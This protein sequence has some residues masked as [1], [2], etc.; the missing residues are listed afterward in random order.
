MAH[1]L[2][3]LG[4][5]PAPPSQ[6]LGA[7][8]PELASLRARM[9]ARDAALAHVSGQPGAREAVTAFIA[10][11]LASRDTEV[12]SLRE[13]LRARDAA[14]ASLWGHARARKATL[15]SML[16]QLGARS[17][18]AAALRAQLAAATTALTARDTVL[19]STSAELASARAQLAA[20]TTALTARDT[21]AASATTELASAREQLTSTI[22]A[23]AALQGTHAEL[24]LK[25]Q[26][27]E[28][29]VRGLCEHVEMLGA[30]LEEAQA[31]HLE[32]HHAMVSLDGHLHAAEGAI[33]GQRALLQGLQRMV[34]HL[35]VA[36][37]DPVAEPS[38]D[39]A[40]PPPDAPAAE[41]LVDAPAPDAAAADAIPDPA[42][43]ADAALP[44]DVLG[45]VVPDPI[46]DP[47]AAEV[48]H[49]PAGEAVPEAPAGAAHTARCGR[50]W[51][52]L[53]VGA[54]LARD[55]LPGPAKAVRAHLHLQLLHTQLY[56]HGQPC[57]R[58]C[59]AALAP[60]TAGLVEALLSEC[61]SACTL[62]CACTRSTK[63]M[64]DR[65]LSAIQYPAFSAEITSHLQHAHLD[66][67]LTSAACARW[68]TRCTWG[69][70]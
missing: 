22:A 54:L 47:A 9:R 64:F 40:P 24:T 66:R 15:G 28:G 49:E 17:A 70:R 65:C 32:D 18:E 39:L 51:G 13:Q 33:E 48:A 1:L 57:F 20:A 63:L 68:R 62:C 42:A 29:L 11:Q 58:V 43:P 41:A 5:A 67:Q 2:A 60:H 4:A 35:P 16:E 52:G 10:K 55:L 6:R 7:R 36:D 61:L 3:G 30:Q 21:V 8:D 27:A 25:H 38:A 56:C 59:Q 50:V 23:L 19:A 26:A 69:A 12:A 34:V 53:A 46:P 37:P 45:G 44:A 14:L 31:G